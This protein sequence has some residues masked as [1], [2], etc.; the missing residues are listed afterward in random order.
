M[1]IIIKQFK[2]TEKMINENDI[3]TTPEGSMFIIPLKF[4][5]RTYVSDKISESVDDVRIAWGY[6]FETYLLIDIYDE[7]HVAD[8]TPTKSDIETLE[9]ILREF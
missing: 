3:V 9:R 8:W 5:W 4:P 1:D 6:P 7:T 2:V